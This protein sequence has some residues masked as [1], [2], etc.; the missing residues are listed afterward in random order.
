VL[1]VVMLAA[2]CA[3]AACSVSGTQLPSAPTTSGTARP[4]ASASAQDSQDAVVQR[5][6]A[7]QSVDVSVNKCGDYYSTYPTGFVVDAPTEI[8]DRTGEH[9]D[10]CG[11]NRYFTSDEA[12]EE[13]DRKCAGYLAGCAQIVE[14]CRK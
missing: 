7:Q 5:V 2:L 10:S 12:R 11:G 9:I 14:S 4:S 3:V 6:C 13:A 8:Y 1:R